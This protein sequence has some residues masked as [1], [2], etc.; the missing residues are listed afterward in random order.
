MRRTLL[1]QHLALPLSIVEKITK[2]E[3]TVVSPATVPKKV[4][5]KAS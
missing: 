3:Y 5:S 4:S 1:R 2:K